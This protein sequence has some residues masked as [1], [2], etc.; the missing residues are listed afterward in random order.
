MY[1]D[2][3]C[4]DSIQSMAKTFRKTDITQTYVFLGVFLVPS[5]TDLLLT[6]YRDWKTLLNCQVSWSDMRL[7][8]LTSKI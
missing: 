7:C 8:M 4:N 5:C 3:A 6:L 1:L 2:T